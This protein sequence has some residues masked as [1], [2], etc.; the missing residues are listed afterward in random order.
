MKRLKRDNGI[1]LLEAL[2]A[3]A[4]AGAG[5]AALAASLSWSLR[6]GRLARRHYQAGLLLES[7]VLEFESGGR[8]EDGS[9]EDPL[10]G[11]TDWTAADAGGDEGAWRRRSVTLSWGSRSNRRSLVLP[12]HRP[13]S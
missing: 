3:V 4:V 12:V 5:V 9:A 2:L 6:A 8:W 10:L 1:V 7:K 13:W 11:L